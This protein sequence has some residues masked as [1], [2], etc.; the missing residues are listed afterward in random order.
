MGIGMHLV[1]PGCLAVNRVP[2]ER[3]GDNPRCGKCGALVLDGK[4]LALT[5]ASFARLITNH[6]LPV[7]V[8]FWA[9]WCGPCKMMAP[10]FERVAA[11]YASSV[12]FAKVDTEHEPTLSQRYGIRSIPTLILFKNGVEADRISGALDAAGLKSWLSRI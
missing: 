7:V 2:Q 8:D 3:L 11:Q 9:D 6:E 1:C 5:T 4:P 12:R 10:V